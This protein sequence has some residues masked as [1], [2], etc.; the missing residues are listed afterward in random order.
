MKAKTPL[1]IL[2]ILSLS[3]L[4]ILFLFQ[5]LKEE[6]YTTYTSASGEARYNKFLALEML[7]KKFNFSVT[8]RRNSDFT[9][10]DPGKSV[11]LISDNK[12]YHNEQYQYALL[13]WIKKGGN[14]IILSHFHKEAGEKYQI[15]PETDIYSEWVEHDIEDDDITVFENFQLT[16]SHDSVID[17]S[18]DSLWQL[19]DAHGTHA[20]G[21]QI[22]KGTLTVFN[23]LSLFN[24]YQIADHNHAGFFISLMKKL[25]AL[26]LTHI[27]QPAS[28]GLSDIYAAYPLPFYLLAILILFSAWFYWGHFGPV[29]KHIYTKEKLFINHLQYAGQYLWRYA[30]SDELY[31]AVYQQAIDNIILKHPDWN[32]MSDI[33]KTDMASAKSGL[34]SKTVKETLFFRTEKNE[35]NFLLFCRHITLIRDSL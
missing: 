18:Y 11:V 25:N 31:N 28:K 35:H 5:N 27:Q 7:L 17:S 6:E 3:A 15:L 33:Q 32:T 10:P 19:K 20:A 30:S 16:I 13:N 9:L 26:H 4:I 22:D 2:L 14:L 29:K 12:I 8:N 34:D 23:D 1:L 21:Y 24:N